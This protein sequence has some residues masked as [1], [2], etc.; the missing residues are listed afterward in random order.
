MSAVVGQEVVKVV[1]FATAKDAIAVGWSR[2][3]VVVDIEVE[4]VAVTLITFQLRYV[5]S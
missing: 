3:Q 5:S 2:S 4:V 1:S